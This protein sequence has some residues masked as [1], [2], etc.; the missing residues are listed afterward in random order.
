[1]T[2]SKNYIAI[3]LL[4]IFYLVGIFGLSNSEWQN[5]FLSLTPFNLLLT[6]G[7]FLWA[8]G[9]LNKSLILSFII[10]FLI[11]YGVEVAGVYT[12]VLFGHYQ[13]GAAL[14][15]KL[16][17]VPLIIGINWFLLAI[18]SR[19]IVEKISTKSYVQIVLSALMMVFLDVLIE[20][21]AIQLD[22][23]KWENNIIPLQNFIM[24]FIISFLIQLILSK[25]KPSLN[26]VICL[27]LYFTQLAFFG[28][29]NVSL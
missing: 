27:A 7:I 23:W 10:I 29:L 4:V 17:E 13:Y 16:F 26:I 5:M 24:W 18:T 1:M 11:G 14:G 21:V 2:S 19:G 25:L 3:A 15:L 28:I 9:Y 6:L 8:N 22:F 12:G 20:P